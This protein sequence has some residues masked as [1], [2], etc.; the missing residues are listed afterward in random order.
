MLKD[1]V[2]RRNVALAEISGLRIMNLSCECY[3]RE[4]LGVE[5]FSQKHNLKQQKHKIIYI[6]KYQRKC[7]RVN[8]LLYVSS[9]KKWS[10][11]KH[12]VT[13]RMSFSH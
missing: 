4:D 12:K 9:V 10:V 13:N 11:I 8:K 2:S 5:N 6:S 1:S 3:Q 7:E